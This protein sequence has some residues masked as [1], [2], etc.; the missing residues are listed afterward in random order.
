MC[1][2]PSISWPNFFQGQKC[3]KS[4]FFDL[5][6]DYIISK[7]PPRSSYNQVSHHP[8]DSIFDGLQASGHNCRSISQSNFS[9]GQK[10]PKSW[11]FTYSTTIKP[12]KHLLDPRVFKS[13]SIHSIAFLTGYNLVFTNVLRLLGEFFS[14]GKVP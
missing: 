9:Q 6:H 3:P 12:P 14:E 1:H 7:S 11:F 2:C 8:F 10:C 13:I 4:W 5:C